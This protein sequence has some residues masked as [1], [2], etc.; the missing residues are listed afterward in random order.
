M[1]KLLV[2]DDEPD[3]HRVLKPILTAAGWTVVGAQT[4]TQGLRAARSNTIRVV[5]LDLGLPDVDGKEIIEQ[6]Q[7]TNPLSII[8]ISARHQDSEKVAAL[9]AGADDYVDKPFNLEELLARIRVADRRAGSWV[10]APQIFEMGEVRM[11]TA[12]RLVTLA[13]HEVRLSPKEFAILRELISHG[14]QVVTHRRLLMA[15]WGDVSVDPQYLRGYIA[16]LRQKFEEDPSEPRI[17]RSEPG[18]GY[19]LTA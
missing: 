3:I 11:D 13:G 8:V 10:T 16:L 2:I 6:L 17:L 4:A 5:L 14:G 18:V 9:D 19:R 15:G 7:T 1:T 12:Q